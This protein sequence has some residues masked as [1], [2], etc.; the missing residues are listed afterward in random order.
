M[1]SLF[2]L[3]FI[4]ICIGLEI[5]H[6]PSESVISGFPH[7]IQSELIGIQSKV[8]DARIHF[9]K[10]GNIEFLYT[11]LSKIS[12]NIYSGE[13]PANFITAPSIEYCIIFELED[14][15][16]IAYPLEN[17]FGNPVQLKIRD[18]SESTYSFIDDKIVSKS[19][20]LSPKPESKINESDLLI[21]VS[22]FNEKNIDVNSIK[23]KL[24]N[25][26]ITKKVTVDGKSLTYVPNDILPGEH[27]IEITVK[28]VFGIEYQPIFWKF[29]VISDDITY[30]KKYSF[31]QKG[32]ISTDAT[33]AIIDEKIVSIQNA[34]FNYRMN[35]DWAKIRLKLKQTSLESQLLQPKNRYSIEF[36]TPFVNLYLG[37]VYPVINEFLIN[38]YR[39]RGAQILFN[40][41]YLY[42]NYAQGQ[43]S[44]VIQGDL[45]DDAMVADFDSTS[46]LITISR[47]NY[48]FTR[49][50]HLASFGLKYKNR[51]NWNLNV[52]KAKDNIPSVYGT[53]N[54]AVI[55]LPWE[56][57][58]YV[59]SVEYS[60]YF[61]STEIETDDSSNIFISYNINHKNLI[62]NFNDIFDDSISFAYRRL[63]K[64]WDGMSPQDN[65][66]IGSDFS[67]N[68]DKHRAEFSTG[69]AFSLLNQNIWDP[70]VSKA[71]LDTLL[72]EFDDGYFN[73]FYTEESVVV[74]NDL[75]LI[76]IN[77][78]GICDIEDSTLATIDTEGIALVDIPFDPADYEEYFHMNINQVPLLP[79]DIS[80][81][82]I[83]I[84]EILHMPSLA[85]HLKLK[86]NYFGHSI[87][88]GYRQIGPE[89]NTLGNPY[90]EKDIREQTFSDRVR[91]FHNR[92]LLFVKWEGTD[93]DVSVFDGI[94]GRTNRTDIGFNMF[95]GKGLPAFN[96]NVGWDTRN[97]G[98]AEIDTI[99]FETM[100]EDTAG[101]MVSNP[102]TSLYD[103]RENTKTSRLNISISNDF[104]LFNVFHSV[105]CN[106]YKS[107]KVDI[108]EN[109]RDLS[110]STYYSPASTN[111]FLSVN[112]HS[113]F[114]NNWESN[115]FLSTSFNSFSKGPWYY[116]EQNLF[117]LDEMIYYLLPKLSGKAKGGFNVSY[118]QGDVADFIQF[119][120]KAGVVLNFLEDFVMRADSDFRYKIV[121]D[122]TI[123]KNLH[124]SAKLSYRF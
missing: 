109:D 25:I 57:T 122:S 45:E 62:N 43:I 8:I 41:K 70:V 68:F 55:N 65:I 101:S 103:I 15:S 108:Y 53:L 4:S 61:H 83:G 6:N 64:D 80:S 9:R 90:L 91:L 99:Y 14:G 111:R 26:N 7:L 123:Y 95:P 24:D 42:A 119:S 88:L 1:R 124:F 87:K 32:K 93:N 31:N 54:D 71:G 66:V 44:R 30:R 48:T 39:L 84:Y 29:T 17:P 27:R 94:V 52:L 75:I 92:G 74:C 105:S 85:Y 20:I 18:N 11:S 13:I 19:I 63:T 60:S 117:V 104:E 50:A 113:S 120:I 21:A 5:R 115:L 89:F 33:Q 36:S 40:S 86:L 67:F 35:L 23:I 3:S 78:N 73:Q 51:F 22:F 107:D 59:D 34:Y 82:K 96:F 116:Q 69:F 46:N 38:G 58:E 118:G 12:S 81:G 56:L 76:D 49:N 47:D 114:D 77:G 72:D 2:L 97:N 16:A 79:I 112:L 121:D 98:I 100:I 28:N 37:D 10:T 102:D 106:I 110:D